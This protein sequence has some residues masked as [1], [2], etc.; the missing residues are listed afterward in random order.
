MPKL[1]A[2]VVTNGEN[3]SLR[4]SEFIPLLSFEMRMILF[5]KK[6]TETL[7]EEFWECSIAFWIKAASTLYNPSWVA[8]KA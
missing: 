5:D 1:V 7:F 4:M 2:R 3:T 6:E 8:R